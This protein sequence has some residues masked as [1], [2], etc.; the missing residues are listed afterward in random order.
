MTNL[1]QR[2]VTLAWHVTYPCIYTQ[3]GAPSGLLTLKSCIDSYLRVWSSHYFKVT[4]TAWEGLYNIPLLPQYKPRSPSRRLVTPYY[5]PRSL[6]LRS[7][8]LLNREPRSLAPRTLR[9]HEPRSLPPRFVTK[10][11]LRSVPTM[12]H[13][14]RCRI[15]ALAVESLYRTSGLSLTSTTL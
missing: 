12:P 13:S 9:Q 5:G 4:Y 1:S 3:L 10:P 2:P 11:P 14:L 7:S 15:R 8:P 6:S